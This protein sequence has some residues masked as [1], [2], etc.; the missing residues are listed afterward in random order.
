MLSIK[1]EIQVF[2]GN[3][4]MVKSGSLLPGLFF[5]EISW[6][7]GDKFLIHLK[8]GGLICTFEE[9]NRR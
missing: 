4:D 6:L 1:R 9:L 7:K 5:A 8:S 2:T 3:F